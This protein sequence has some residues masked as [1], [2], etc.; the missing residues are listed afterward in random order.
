MVCFWL[1]SEPAH[2][3]ETWGKWK[4]RGQGEN[5]GNNFPPVFVQMIRLT[6]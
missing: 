5:K 2:L 4:K 3:R 6:G 1:A